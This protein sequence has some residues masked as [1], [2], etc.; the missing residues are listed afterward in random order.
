MTPSNGT[1]AMTSHRKFIKPQTI[2][3][4]ALHN[5]QLF[6]QNHIK[7]NSTH[8]TRLYCYQFDDTVSTESIS[9]PGCGNRSHNKKTKIKNK[10]CYEYTIHNHNHI[11]NIV[12]CVE[13]EVASFPLHT[14]ISWMAAITLQLH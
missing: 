7:K 10:N 2:A 4:F 3:L 6:I 1:I 8:A 5:Q 14:R 9:P 13:V 11:I 12:Q